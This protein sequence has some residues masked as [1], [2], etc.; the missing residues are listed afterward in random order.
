MRLG[1][2]FRLLLSE[3][4]EAAAQRTN[5]KKAGVAVQGLDGAGLGQAMPVEVEGSQCV[6]WMFPG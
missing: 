1:G 5:W 4:S 3:A 6:P 2:R